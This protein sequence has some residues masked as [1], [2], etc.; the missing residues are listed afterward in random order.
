[1]I[2]GCPVNA[3][4]DIF[5]GPFILMLPCRDTS[6]VLVGESP[7]VISMPGILNLKLE[8]CPRILSGRTKGIRSKLILGY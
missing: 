3:T 6:L 5:A 7:S 4:L 2:S 1:V 8:P